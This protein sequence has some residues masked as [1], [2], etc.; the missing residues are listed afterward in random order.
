MLEEKR[1]N[2]AAVLGF[3]FAMLLIFLIFFSV[4]FALGIIA[5][6]LLSV[7]S[8]CGFVFSI[9]GWIQAVKL[10]KGK[11]GFA[12]AGTVISS[13]WFWVIFMML[14]GLLV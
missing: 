10:Q 2:W 7:D 5:M 9:V 3:S 6:L 12:I 4:N 8:F 11:L 14:I 1:F 13:I